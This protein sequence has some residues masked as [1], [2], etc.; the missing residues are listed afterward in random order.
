MSRHISGGYDYKMVLQ[1]T[2]QMNSNVVSL[3]ME[4]VLASKT[5]QSVSWIS[6]VP[7]IF[8]ANSL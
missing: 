3:L 1:G 6:C 5:G 7:V 4:S 2:I 8:H